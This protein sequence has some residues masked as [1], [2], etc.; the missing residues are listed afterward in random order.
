MKGYSLIINESYKAFL[1]AANWNIMKVGICD[2]RNE[3]FCCKE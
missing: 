1:D 3:G 2:E